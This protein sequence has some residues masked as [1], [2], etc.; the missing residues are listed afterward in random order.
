MSILQLEDIQ[1]KLS[2][3]YRAKV[4]DFP[5]HFKGMIPTAAPATQTDEVAAVINGMAAMPLPDPFRDVL[6]IWDF[7]NLSLAGF[8]FSVNEKYADAIAK[9]NANQ[10]GEWWADREDENRPRSLIMIAQSDPYVLLLDLN[11]G[12]I[13]AFTSTMG[14]QN[15]RVIA[16]D[17]HMLLRALGSAELLSHQAA[18]TEAFTLE[19][20]Q[21]LGNDVFKQFWRDQVDHWAQFS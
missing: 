7:G 19:L 3:K 20:V 12:D 5:E 10:S 9:M 17:L 1:N 16:H 15:H 21:R 4:E 8:R 14:S 18:N 13:L 6:K 11:S 2:D